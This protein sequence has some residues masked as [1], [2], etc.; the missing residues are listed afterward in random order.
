MRL[1]ITNG[2][3]GVIGSYLYGLKLVR[4]QSRMR[5]RLID[6]LNDRNELYVKDRKALQEEHAE[7]DSKG[8]PV[9]KDSNYV[10]PDMVSFS[11]DLRVLN[12]EVYVIEGGDYR[13]M[14]RTIKEMLKKFEDE[15]YEGPDSEAYDYL[16]D[17]LD[18]D[19]EGEGNDESDNNRD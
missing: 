1:E 15:E 2:K 3:I 18:V 11:Q 13:D 6:L 14:L 5:R 4:K 10:I 7:K 9:I 17:Q 16:C 12:D 8:E 19:N